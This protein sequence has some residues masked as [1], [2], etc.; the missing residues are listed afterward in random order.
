MDLTEA[1]EGTAEARIERERREGRV[2]EEVEGRSVEKNDLWRSED[3]IVAAAKAK[4]S[5]W[6]ELGRVGV[7][8]WRRKLKKW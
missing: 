2:E 7:G 5:T 3:D 8:W 4:E 1:A 6:F